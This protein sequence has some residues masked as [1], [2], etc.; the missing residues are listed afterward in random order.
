M[1]KGNRA[2]HLVLGW[3]FVSLTACSARQIITSSNP[4]L[5]PMPASQVK[6]ALNAEQ[7]DPMTDQLWNLSKVGMPKVWDQ[8]M[9]SRR[10]VVAVLGTGVDYT[11]EDLA[12]NM[13]LNAREWKDLTPG[14]QDAR[15][16][17]DDDGNGYVDD[18]VGYDFVD[19]DGLPFDKHGQGTAMAGIIGA[20]SKNGK[21][22]RGIMKEVSLLPV[23]FVDGSGRFD[24]P[25]L[26]QALQYAAVM[27]SDVVVVHLPHHEFSLNPRRA[28]LVAFEKSSLT[29]ALAA[30]NATD[31]PV[32]VSAGNSASVV[33]AENSLIALVRKQPNVVVVTAVDDKDVRPMLANFSMKTV[34]TTAPGSDI[35]TTAPGG[36]YDRRSGTALAAA[37]VAGAVGLAVNQ[38]FGR[39][40]PEKVKEALVSPEASD[41]VETM[42]YQTIGGNR[43]NV[44]RFLSYLEKTK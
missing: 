11:H 6:Q 36:S 26:V 13:F 8:A 14:K 10:V 22:V 1:K 33:E 32:I 9:G 3:L 29:Q 19:D 4:N 28:A 41:A 31:T 39:V 35:M 44:A 7:L 27:K 42:R 30:L 17:T 38:F 21:G 2:I 20:V 37:H 23:R 18:F 16:A 40:N 24:F 34:H 25:H 43:L 5:D 15:N 12:P